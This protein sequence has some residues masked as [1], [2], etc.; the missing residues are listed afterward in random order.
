MRLDPA[1]YFKPYSHLYGAL[2]KLDD[3]GQSNYN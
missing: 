1:H 2:F 3:A